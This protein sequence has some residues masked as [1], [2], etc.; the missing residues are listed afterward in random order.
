MT[1][2]TQGNEREEVRLLLSK[3]NQ[4]WL[5]GR[6][7]ELNDFFHDDMVIKGPEL[8]EMGRGKDV[9]V[10]SYKD[11]IS[12]A[13]VQ[14]FKESDAA[15]D[16]WGSTAVASYSWEMT[17]QMKGQNYRESGRDIFVFARDDAG[18]RAVWRAV[19]LSPQA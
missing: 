7:E 14:E 3:I 5:K 4:A 13:V 16:V 10:G 12:Q 1:D 15:I 19:L 9:C 11:F 6:L 8:Q 2:A 17:Y 18:W